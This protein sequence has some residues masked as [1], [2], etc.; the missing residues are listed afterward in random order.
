MDIVKKFLNIFSQSN[1]NMQ[2]LSGSN[3]NSTKLIW[4][5]KKIF[6]ELIIVLIICIALTKINILSFLYFIYFGYLTTTKK[7]MIKFYILYGILLIILIIQSII[8]ITNIS[9]DTSPRININLLKLLKEKLDIPWYIN[10]YNIEK[11]ICIFLWVRS[12]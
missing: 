10:I 11:K 3:N 5:L 1:K 2:T 9:E 4:F 8:Y 12:K 6:E 7:T